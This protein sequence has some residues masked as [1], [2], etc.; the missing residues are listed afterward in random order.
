MTNI[1]WFTVVNVQKINDKYIVLEHSV[2]NKRNRFKIDT[3]KGQI[4]L[5]AAEK[6]VSKICQKSDNDIKNIRIILRETTHNSDHKLFFYKANRILLPENKWKKAVFKKDRFGKLLNKPMV[7]FFKY[8]TNIIP[9]KAD[10]LNHVNPLS[11]WKY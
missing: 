8:K 4:P 2:L 1:R 9:V 3:S 7:K 6:A 11:N 10:D 5:N